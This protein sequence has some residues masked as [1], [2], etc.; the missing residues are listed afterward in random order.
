MNI[1]EALQR[2]GYE[3]VNLTG[4]RT[5]PIVKRARHLNDSLFVPKELRAGAMHV[6]AFLFR[7]M[8]CKLY[9]PVALGVGCIDFWALVDLNDTQK[10]W[11]CE[12]ESDLARFTDQTADLIDFGYGW[13]E[14]GHGIDIDPRSKDLIWRAH[15]QLEAAAVTIVQAYNF[16]GSV[17]AALLG[18]ELALKAGLAAHGVEDQTLKSREWGHNLQK[19]AEELGAREADFDTERVKRVVSQFPNYVSSR[20]SGPTP[21][22]EDTGNIIMGAQYI[23]S[24]VTRRF[25]D[26]DVRQD[27]PEFQRRSYPP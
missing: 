19:L 1:G 13:L 2:F 9:A 24:E 16:R 10:E 23:G 21:S 12:S 3:S 26:R 22:R 17:Q 27:D 15:T 20:Y 11:L 4:R 8:F 7:D 5:T 6:G 14:F 25:S 18:T